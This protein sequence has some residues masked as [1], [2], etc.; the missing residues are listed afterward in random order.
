MQTHIRT[1]S[2]PIWETATVVLNVLAFTLVGLQL[3]PIPDM[4]EPV[5][6][7]DKTNSRIGE[8]VAAAVSL[9]LLVLL[10]RR[11]SSST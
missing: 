2:F 1:S 9:V 5:W 11:P 8:A 7:A 6:Y 3:G 4:Y 10:L